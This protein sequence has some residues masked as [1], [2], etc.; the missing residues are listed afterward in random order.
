MPRIAN[1]GNR[2]LGALVCPGPIAYILT[3]MTEAQPVTD[4]KPDL[5]PV[6]RWLLVCAAM[7]FVMV[8]LGGATRLTESGLSMVEWKPLTV[9]PPLTESQWQ[10]E[11]ANYQQYPEFQK[12]NR[13]M[14][15]NDYKEIY[16]LEYV[17][18]LWGRLIGVVF[19]IPFL[20]FLM[21]RRLDRP[22]AWRLVGILALGGAQGVLGWFM[23]ASGLIGHPDVSHYRL[24]AHLMM[25]FIVFA[26]LVWTALDLIQAGK[27]QPEKIVH[28]KI[29]RRALIA[30]ISV[31][32]VAL[33]G[34]LV[35]GLN[36]G[37]IYNT[38]PLMNGQLIPYGLFAMSPWWVNLFES[39]LTV[40]FIHR[41][42]G[43]L[44]VVKFVGMWLRSR[45]AP[46]PPR[47]RHLTYASLGMVFAQAALG[48]A[49]LLL[50][51]PL[52]LALAHQSGAL[53]LFAL[54]LWLAHDLG[55]ASTPAAAQVKIDTTAKPAGQIP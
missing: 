18:R 2:V 48:I 13:W 12:K 54:T 47:A 4:P 25:A 35:A 7:V 9:M 49:T 28:P 29:T 8:M 40:Q 22:L 38:F 6:A 23:V 19:A 10:A 5:R 33:Y 17:H 1:F 36:A 45:S 11:F 24:V 44:L 41:V 32:L 31:P 46:M 27:P 14:T 50:V 39:Y 53:V 52:P 37:V 15:L 30:V 43:I 55:M 34:A 42:L 51:V 20:W 26:A 3:T 16:W 21:Q